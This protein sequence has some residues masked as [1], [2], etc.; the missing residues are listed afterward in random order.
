MWNPKN[1]LQKNE[2]LIGVQKKQPL[3]LIQM[4]AEVRLIII[5]V[6]W[7]ISLF[8]CRA[9]LKGQKRQFLSHACTQR[10][11]CRFHCWCS[12]QLMY[13]YNKNLLNSVQYFAQITDIIFP[14]IN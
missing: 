8:V 13:M 9:N 4:Y 10:L 14:D 1:I 12:V 2:F 3:Q 6:A 11:Q 7:P 5:V